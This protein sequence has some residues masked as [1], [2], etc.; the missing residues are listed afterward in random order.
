MVTSSSD[1]YSGPDSRA[2]MARLGHAGL[3][4]FYLFAAL[5]W[6]PD[7][8]LQAFSERGFI[9]YS[10]VILAFLAGSLW[11]SANVRD[12]SDKISRLL[13]SNLLAVLGAVVVMLAAPLVAA[14][15]LAVL[16]L[17]QL[18]YET[19]RPTSRWYLSLRRRLT[20]LSLPAYALLLGSQLT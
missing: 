16:H 9:L 20:W 13:A 6:L 14:I 11:G 5:A 7:T 1:G 18:W 17:A 3:A 4:P 15:M 2:V 12:G 8:S 10:L 19:S